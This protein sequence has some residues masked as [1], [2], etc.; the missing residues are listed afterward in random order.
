MKNI[1]FVLLLIVGSS[2]TPKDISINCKDVFKEGN[3]LK[4]QN[5]KYKG[6]TIRI[7]KG[8]HYEKFS[9]KTVLK[10]SITWLS[11]CEAELKIV[12][13]KHNKSSFNIGD[14]IVL[15]FKPI[16]NKKYAYVIKGAKGKGAGGVLIVQ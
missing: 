11:E 8:F 14:S 7:K 4:Y 13:I 9:N 2:F 16:N 10:S 6:T 3:V 15:V 1:I 5:P 12:K